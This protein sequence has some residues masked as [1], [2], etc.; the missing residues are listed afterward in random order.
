L[1]K[2]ESFN[3]KLDNFLTN[4]D[5]VKSFLLR[6]SHGSRGVYDYGKLYGKDELSSEQI[7]E[8]GS[9]LSE[10]RNVLEELNRINIICTH[11]DENEQ[12]DLELYPLM[13]I[14][15]DQK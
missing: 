3:T 13:Q 1:Q 2:I 10:I 12:F 11:I 4:K 6:W 9:L 14:G 8:I 5:Y 15:F 7:E